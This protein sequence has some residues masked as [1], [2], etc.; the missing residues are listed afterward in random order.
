MTWPRD[1]RTGPGGGL[2]TGPDGGMSTGPGGGAST[3]PGGGLSTGPGGGLSTGPGGGLSTGPGG[4]LSTGPGGGLSTGPG[5][6]LSTGPGGGFATEPDGEPSSEQGYYR[7]NIPPLPQFIAELE[8]RGLLR[9]ANL[10]K[11]AIKDVPFEIEPGE[12]VR[13]IGR[14]GAG[15]ST[16]LKILS[17]LTEPAPGWAKSRGRIGSLLEVGTGFH[18]DRA[19][20]YL[21]QRQH[22]GNEAA[23]NLMPF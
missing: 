21:S 17:R 9:E 13:I 5:G 12:V 14:N 11:N 8:R 20:K 22:S 7:S 3:G 23:G 16:L 10:I 18:P 15:K 4:R 6:G 19:R 1:R 2:S